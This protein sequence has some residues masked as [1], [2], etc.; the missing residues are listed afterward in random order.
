MSRP[1][2]RTVLRQPMAR[3][4]SLIAWTGLGRP[5]EQKR[6]VFVENVLNI[7]TLHY[8][9]E[10]A[11]VVT[12]GRIDPHRSEQRFFG[13]TVITM[14]LAKANIHGTASTMLAARLLESMGSDLRVRKAIETRIHR[15]IARLLGARTSNEFEAETESRCEGMVISI[16]ADF[17][18]AIVHEE[19]TAL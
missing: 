8:L 16:K 2:P 7:D 11:D 18:S 9:L 15:E 12:E 19:A 13:S 10:T 4:E 3:T 1:D 17:D 6:T 5:T 14:N